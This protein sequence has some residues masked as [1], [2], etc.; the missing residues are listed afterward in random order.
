MTGNI[1][2]N[3]QVRIMD[4]CF[5]GELGIVQVVRPNNHYPYIVSLPNHNELI[6]Y[7][8]GQIKRE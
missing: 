5:E 2:V 8:E 3:D 1:K 4:G 7:L 6:L